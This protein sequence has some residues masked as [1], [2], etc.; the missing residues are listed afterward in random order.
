MIEK[1]LI[2]Y[3]ILKYYVNKI[4]I[5][6]RISYPLEYAYSIL[7]YHIRSIKRRLYVNWDCANMKRL[8]ACLISVLFIYFLLDTTNSLELK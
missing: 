2:G 7:L 6:L 3:V 4:Y 1:Y 8:M 5:Y